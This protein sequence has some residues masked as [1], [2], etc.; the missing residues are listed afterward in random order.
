[1]SRQGAPDEVCGLLALHGAVIPLKNVHPLPEDHFR[2]DPEEF[3]AVR[4]HLV[5]DVLAW[6]S[7]PRTRAEP[8]LDDLRLMQRIGMPMAIVSLR[9]RIPLIRVFAVEPIRLRRV[10]LASYRVC[11]MSA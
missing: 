1:L 10:E 2:Y 8:S 3:Y 9:A 7:H 11:A 4:A 6:H 5:G